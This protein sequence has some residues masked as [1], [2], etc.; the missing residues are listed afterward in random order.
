MMNYISP[1]FERNLVIQKILRKPIM[2]KFRGHRGVEQFEGNKAGF[3]SEGL[4]PL[5]R[6]KPEL[7]YHL[8]EYIK[9]AMKDYSPSFDAIYSK[10]KEAVLEYVEAA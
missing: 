2:Y 1:N 3:A 10:E 6:M 8:D 5:N 7:F 4:K 9:E